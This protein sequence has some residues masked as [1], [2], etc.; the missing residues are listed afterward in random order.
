[1]L[2]G[3]IIYSYNHNIDTHDRVFI[4]DKH[5][6]RD[7]KPFHPQSLPV[8]GC[9]SAPGGAAGIGNRESPTFGVCT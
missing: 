2:F 3:T 8:E 4:H 7:I 5:F 6:K 9:L 1:M